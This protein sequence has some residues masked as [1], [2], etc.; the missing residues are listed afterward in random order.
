[1]APQNQPRSE[2]PATSTACSAT[3]R[4]ADEHP[5]PPGS[6]ADRVHRRIDLRPSSAEDVAS[7]A[8]PSLDHSRANEH[9]SREPWQS[10]QKRFRAPTATSAPVRKSACGARTTG[11]TRTV[12]SSVDPNGNGYRWGARLN[13]NTSSHVEA[14]GHTS[15]HW[16]GAEV[17]RRQSYD[18]R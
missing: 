17:V 16:R 4:R 8:A 12:T 6:P 13:I 18:L 2:T 3:A 14:T 7:A 15:G 9:G 5:K 10:S 1:M 11:S